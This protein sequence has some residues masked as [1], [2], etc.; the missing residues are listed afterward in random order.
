M[1]SRIA[2][3]SSYLL[4]EVGL[5]SVPSTFKGNRLKIL[6]YYGSITYLLR[7]HGKHFVDG[8]KEDNKFSKAA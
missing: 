4:N 8:V 7:E 5:S 3:F 1:S 6:F 2:D